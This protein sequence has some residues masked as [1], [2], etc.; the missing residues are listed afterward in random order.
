MLQIYKKKLVCVCTETSLPDDFKHLLTA[1]KIEY[2]SCNLSQDGI[3]V[4]S[5][6]KKKPQ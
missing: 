6:S 5:F 4:N 2:F 1:E 3:K